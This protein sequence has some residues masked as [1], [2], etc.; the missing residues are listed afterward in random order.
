MLKSVKKKNSY[1][2]DLL[3]SVKYKGQDQRH[4]YFAHGYG[5]RY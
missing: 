4:A 1:Q 5:Q 2:Q 3:A